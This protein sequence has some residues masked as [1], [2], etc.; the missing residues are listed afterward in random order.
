ML[1]NATP[2]AAPAAATQRFLAQHGVDTGSLDPSSLEIARPEGA[3]VPAQP[4]GVKEHLEA[5]LLLEEER[6]MTEVIDEANQVIF[7]DFEQLLFENMQRE[8]EEYRK[9]LL[10]DYQISSGGQGRREDS[11]P[12]QE[13]HRQRPVPPHRPREPSRKRER[14]G[15]HR[16]FG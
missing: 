12:P 14:T 9:E 6:V 13:E 3:Q 4:L 16:D 2:A 10:G 7:D 15:Q 1:A 5:L 11:I 8:H